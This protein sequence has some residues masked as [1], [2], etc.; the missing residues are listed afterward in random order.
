MIS[1]FQVTIEGADK[2]KI[3]KRGGLGTCIPTVAFA[4]MM[5]LLPLWQSHSFGDSDKTPLS[6]EEKFRLGERMYREGILPSGK[7]MRTSVKGNLSLPGTIFS[8]E[9][10]HLRSGL[11]AFQDNVFTPPTNGAKLFKPQ[12]VVAPPP[13]EGGPYRQLQSTARRSITGHSARVRS[14]PMNHWLTH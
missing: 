8:C 6:A 4:I 3:S 7:P 2:M 1:P 10:C 5:L 14:I 13:N 11:G 12:Q 9:S